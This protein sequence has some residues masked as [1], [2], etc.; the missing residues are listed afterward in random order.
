MVFVLFFFLSLAQGSSKN[1]S[2][3]N[4]NSKR[5][6][7][8]DLF[9]KNEEI[10]KISSLSELQNKQLTI[11][12]ISD[13]CLEGL[14]FIFVNQTAGNQTTRQAYLSSGLV[15]NNL[16]DYDTCENI[17][18]MKYVVLSYSHETPVL[19]ITL[20]GPAV[21]TEED[22]TAVPDSIPELALFISPGYSVIFPKDYQSKHYGTYSD[23]AIFILI[24][25]SA[26]ALMAAVATW[27]DYYLKDKNSI[28]LKILL[29]FSVISNGQKLLTSRAQERLGKKDTLEV[30]N[31]VRVLSLG[32]VILWHNTS[33][34]F[35]FSA[36]SNFTDYLDQFTKPSYILNYTATYAVDSFFWLSGLLMSYL[37]IIEAEKSMSVGKFV[38]VYVHRVLRIT[39]VYIFV[40]IFFWTMHIHLGNGPLWFNIGSFYHDCDRYWYSNLI[41]MNNFIPNGGINQCL[42][43]S[44]YL[45]V[46][47]QIFF[48][49]PIIMMLYIKVNKLLGWISVGLLCILNVL[50]AGLIAY[51]FGLNPIML[52]SDNFS[53]SGKS[54]YDNYYYKKPYCRIAP[55][56]LGLACGFVVYSY[57]KYQDT[58]KTYDIIGVTIGK[59]QEKKTV[60]W[61]TFFLGLGLINALIFSEYD[62]VKHP[63]PNNSTKFPFSV[64]NFHHW[65]E[66]QNIAFIAFERV[67]FGLGLSMILLPILLG[68]FKE[69][70]G[71]LS[72]YPWSVLAKL[73]FTIY[74]IH[75]TISQI[76]VK[77]QKNVTE[78]CIY[79]I[80]RDTIYI[81]VIATFFAIPIVLLVELPLS[82]IERVVF[83]K[84]SPKK[85]KTEDPLKEQLLGTNKKSSEDQ[86]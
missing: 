42:G 52:S 79:N 14:Y 15:F 78:F 84:E 4:S 75:I 30:L 77:S 51:H 67:T 54:N 40:L 10:K 35:D 58:G 50:C 8:S 29:S 68:H 86:D 33:N 70:A 71:F 64:Y 27:L 80:I 82:N 76:I 45:A 61:I 59:L 60:R 21:C 62:I 3:F 28:Q 38:M 55:Y 34:Y 2:S 32:W 57:R 69:I 65:S 49:S 85:I 7:L 24:F 81:F 18:G 19:V 31:S 43:V 23:G 9:Q 11:N 5:Q 26:L 6:D 39:P 13:E 36:L 20:C 37:F 56:A 25:I 47:M 41:F 22:Y 73:T 12:K 72:L 46:D 83:G 66:N 53:S 74:L 44:W 16:G 17:E 1:S 63:G 48:I